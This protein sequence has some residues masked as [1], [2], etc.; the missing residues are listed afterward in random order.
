MW[1]TVP[2]D[3]FTMLVDYISASD[4]N[5]CSFVCVNWHDM[6]NHN[7]SWAKQCHKHWL[8]KRIP[9]DWKKYY[10]LYQKQHNL[11]QNPNAH[12]GFCNWITR[13]TQCSEWRTKSLD[14]FDMT[15][16][17]SVCMNKFIS[18]CGNGILFQPIDL[19]NSGYTVYMLDHYTF[20]LTLSFSYMPESPDCKYIY[21]VDLISQE[22]DV[23]DRYCEVIKFWKY[24]Y[25]KSWRRV[26]CVFI[27]PKGVRYVH[28][29]HIIMNHNDRNGISITDHDLRIAY[30]QNEFA[31]QPISVF[32][33]LFDDPKD[34]QQYNII[35]YDFIRPSFAYRCLACNQFNCVKNYCTMQKNKGSDAFI[36]EP[37]LTVNACS[38]SDT[39]QC[40]CLCIQCMRGGRKN[41]IHDM[42]Y[43]YYR[44]NSSDLCLT[45]FY[46]VNKCVRCKRSKDINNISKHTRCYNLNCYYINTFAIFYIEYQSDD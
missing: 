28:L 14:Y 6:A 10:I 27:H 29:T 2:F 37:G 26:D 24:P 20:D 16:L 36:F 40:N 22:F 34:V 7:I 39:A 19:V 45:C 43:N 35:D 8:T 13:N 4:L 1:N 23:L 5:M 18:V 44:K 3:I 33:M 11:V 17:S 32:Q 25:R 46:K 12:N 15:Y 31:G 38:G 9:L 41:K 21:S 42:T 30:P